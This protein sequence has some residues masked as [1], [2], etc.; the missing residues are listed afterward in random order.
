[1]S[2]TKFVCVW[3]NGGF[4]LKSLPAEEAEKLSKQQR[5]AHLAI[6]GTEPKEEEEKQGPAF[7]FV[8][9]DGEF[10]QKAGVRVKEGHKA[11]KPE[12]VAT[13][14]FPGSSG[15]KSKKPTGYQAAI[16]NHIQQKVN[17]R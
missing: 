16:T 17:R 7:A 4:A 6:F 11:E 14:F 12:S 15:S 10:K 5:A 1:M 9:E 13:R 3:E 8:F 2:T